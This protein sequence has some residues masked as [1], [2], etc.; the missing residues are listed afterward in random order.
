MENNCNKKEKLL[1]FHQ[2]NGIGGAVR[3]LTDNIGYL[4]KYYDIEIWLFGTHKPT[5]DYFQNLG[6]RTRVFLDFVPSYYGYPVTLPFKWYLPLR[7]IKSLFKFIK[8]ISVANRALAQS[9]AKV[10]Y[11][12]TSVLGAQAIGAKRAGKRVIWH[13]REEPKTINRLLHYFS[14]ALIR[15]YSDC[16]ICI[17]NTYKKKLNPIN[18]NIVYNY[19]K[20]INNTPQ[21][22]NKTSEFKILFMGGAIP[23]KGLEE[24]L[25]ALVILLKKDINF[26]LTVAGNKPDFSQRHKNFKHIVMQ[27]LFSNFFSRTIQSIFSNNPNLIKK[28]HFTGYVQNIYQLYDKADCL[29]WSASVSH[30][31]RPIMEALSHGIP[32]VGAAHECVTEFISNG[33]NGLT[34]T[35]GNHTELAKQLEKLINNNALINKLTINGKS[36]SIQYFDPQKNRNYLH[37][38]IQEQ[39]TES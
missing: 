1:I 28:V 24:L 36:T 21:I 33:I 14:I 5:I 31:A 3:S 25:E 17:C 29:V 15:K 39:F 12:N 11:L 8:S 4:T 6:Y 37:Q 32:V 20:A 9:D 2:A 34:Y 10:V 38:L 22:D 13:I 18:A 16:V 27:K 7:S 23:H 35:P 26:K 30:F 19:Y